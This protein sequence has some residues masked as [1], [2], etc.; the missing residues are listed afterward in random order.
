[1]QSISFSIPQKAERVADINPTK[2]TREER[3][4]KRVRNV[5]QADKRTKKQQR[6]F[7]I[8]RKPMT[9]QHQRNLAKM[10]N[11]YQLRA[12]RDWHGFTQGLPEKQLLNEAQLFILQA[13]NQCQHLYPSSMRKEIA[14]YLD[15]LGVLVGGMDADS[16]VLQ[17]LVAYEHYLDGLLSMLALCRKYDARESRKS[18]T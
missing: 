8:Q 12:L 4:T 6:L 3:Q 11:S 9:L 10:L 17:Q 2:Q 18:R 14:Q 7:R 16:E 1:M 13:V 5:N 15:S